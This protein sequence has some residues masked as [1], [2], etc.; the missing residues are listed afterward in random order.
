MLEPKNRIQKF[1]GLPQRLCQRPRAQWSRGG[2][3]TSPPVRER[4]STKR[5]VQEQYVTA[6]HE[7]AS[8]ELRYES[9]VDDA[10]E[11]LPEL[12]EVTRSDVSGAFASFHEQSVG[13]WRTDLSPEQLRDV[14]DEAGAL[15]A[16]LGYA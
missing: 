13:R 4:R 12:L 5:V 11:R 6:A 15:L 7:G 9:L 1:S 2:H 16:E 3:S 14:E 8:T 10:A